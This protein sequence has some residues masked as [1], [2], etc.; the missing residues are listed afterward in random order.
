MA[1]YRVE[2]QDT[3]RKVRD[4]ERKEKKE[5]YGIRSKYRVGVVKRKRGKN[6][7]TF[8]ML[9]DPRDVPAESATIKTFTS[10]EAYEFTK[11]AIMNM[12]ET[13]ALRVLTSPFNRLNF[14]FVKRDEVRGIRRLA[15]RAG[16]GVT[17]LTA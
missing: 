1:R 17:V 13:T 3:H 2:L 10:P 6:K 16:S 14:A 7:S 8:Y 15:K 5:R 9:V 12:K 11:E 4:D